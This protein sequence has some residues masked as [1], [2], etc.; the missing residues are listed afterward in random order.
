MTELSLYLTWYDA[1][2]LLRAGLNT[3]ICCA[4]AFALLCRLNLMAKGTT[5]R[6]FRW[7]YV[8]L[9]VAVT[10]SLFSPFIYNEWPTWTRIFEQISFFFCL[11]SASMA[12]KKGVPEYAMIWHTKSS[13]FMGLDPLAAD[14]RNPYRRA[15]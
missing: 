12:W 8:F 2:K 4:L 9:L 5:K 11:H 3:I 15:I 13:D 6:V 10:L 14:D 7:K 1:E